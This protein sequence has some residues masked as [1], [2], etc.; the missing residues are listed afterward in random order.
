VVK[1]IDS[2]T[3]ATRDSEPD[4]AYAGAILTA[5]ATAAQMYAWYADWATGRG[6]HQVTYYRTSDQTSGVA[7]RAPGGREQ[8]QVAVFDAAQLAAR[9][10]INASLSPGTLIYEQVLVGYRVNTR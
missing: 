2:D 7:W 6:Y 1:L 9:Q 5:T 3:V 8:V 10:H 4:P